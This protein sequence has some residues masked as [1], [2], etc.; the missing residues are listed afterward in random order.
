MSA[1]EISLPVMAPKS[2]PFAPPLAVIFTVQLR[3]LSAVSTA[4]A[5]FAASSA[6]RAFSLR[7]MVL[8]ASAVAGMAS[9]R[10]SR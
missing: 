2:L 10:G 3:S 8:M 6:R 4:A 1:S 9:L 7:F 5:R